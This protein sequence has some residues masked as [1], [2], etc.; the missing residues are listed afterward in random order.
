MCPNRSS[1]KSCHNE[2]NM[3]VNENEN[4]CVKMITFSSIK[5]LIAVTIL[6]KI[7]TIRYFFKITQPHNIQTYTKTLANRIFSQIFFLDD[8]FC[9][10]GVLGECHASINVRQMSQTWGHCGWSGSVT[11]FTLTAVAET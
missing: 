8:Y 7:N 3:F 2:F 5:N 4:N 11:V 6:D 1:K 10:Y 9:V